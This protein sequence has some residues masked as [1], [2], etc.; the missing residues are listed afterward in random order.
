[1][2]IILLDNWSCYILFENDD[3][4]NDRERDNYNYDIDIQEGMLKTF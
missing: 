3:V 1:M 2:N 4:R